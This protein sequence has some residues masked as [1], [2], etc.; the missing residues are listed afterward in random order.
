MLGKST[1]SPNLLQEKSFNECEKSVPEAGPASTLSLPTH[2]RRPSS[3]TPPV[4]SPLNPDTH[5]NSSNGKTESEAQSRSSNRA[6]I[7]PIPRIS[8]ARSSQQR[9][10]PRPIQGYK[11]THTSEL[12]EVGSRAIGSTLS[13]RDLGADYTRYFNPFSDSARNSFVDLPSTP[14]PRYQS[15][16]Q[17]GMP[18]INSVPTNPFS[19]P[20]ASTTKLNPDFDAERNGALIDDRL[21][22]P[23]NEKD[24]LSWPLFTDEM[25]DDD[26]M[27]LPHPDDDIKYKTKW[28]DHFSKENITSTLGVLFMIIGLLFIFVAIPAMSS[29]GLLPYNSEYSTPLDQMWNYIPGPEPWAIVNNETYPLLRNVRTG[30]IDPDTPKNALTMTGDNGDK[31]ELVFS[32]EFNDNNRTFYEGDD[33]FWYAPDIWYGATQDLEW[34]DPDAVTTWDGTLEIRLDKFI[35]HGLNFRSG[36]LN[37]WNHLCFK[38]GIFEVSMSLPG[39]AAVMGL[40][41]GAWTMGNLGRPGYLSTTEGMWPYTYQACD[42]GITPNQSSYDGLSHLPGQRLP[43]CTCPGEDHP[44]PGTGR[45]A[46]EI[47]II[48]AGASIGGLPI[49]TQSFQ[50]APFDIWYYPDYEF[51]AFPNYST[52]YTNGYTGGPFQQAISATTNLNKDWYDGRAYQKYSFE[53]V[54]GEGED[55]YIIW[56]VGGE[57]T[58]ILDGRAIGS[59]GNI[60]ARQISQEPMS[61]VLNVGISSAWTQIDW[62]NLLFPT[63]MRVD[64]VRWYQKKGETSVTCDP[65]GFE[66]TQYI[67]EH[68]AAYTNPNFTKWEQAGYE[69]PKHKLNTEC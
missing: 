61:I 32:D 58:F 36:M 17:V 9:P 3:T 63:V 35:N 8:T 49:G 29:V 41:P 25:E 42:A 55:A 4:S 53:Y 47:D 24:H 54:P 59:N 15:N 68:M 43:S 18:L 67:K 30:L 57:T 38:G 2:S 51:T 1:S 23:F 60:Q 20:N 13:L 7:S 39:P 16:L 50:V 52:A 27:H 64:Y 66:T 22:A 21:G 34:Y 19:T 48:E 11:H 46:P 6:G 10:P 12:L 69:W 31:F 14:L 5:S 28:Q 33:P 45:G 44:T 26:E 62:A 56:K 65:P 40:W 37:S